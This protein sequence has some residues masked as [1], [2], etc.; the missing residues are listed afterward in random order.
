MRG[1]RSRLRALRR[2]GKQVVVEREGGHGSSKPAA[3]GER[4]SVA[5]RDGSHGSGGAHASGGRD[6]T[7]GGSGKGPASER[8]S[9][10]TP[11]PKQ[12]AAE[13]RYSSC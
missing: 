9:G 1:W 12:S 10:A 8:P 11:R 2:G 13:K 7:Q 4:E 6:A 3:G 5:G